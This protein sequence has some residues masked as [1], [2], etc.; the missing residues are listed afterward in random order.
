MWDIQGW[1]QLAATSNN[2]GDRSTS[3]SARAPCAALHCGPRLDRVRSHPSCAY[4][5]RTDSKANWIAWT[6]R[7]S[8]LPESTRTLLWTLL[9]TGLCALALFHLA[10]RENKQPVRYKV[11]SPKR[12]ETVEILDEPA[13]KVRIFAS[14]LLASL[15]STPALLTRFVTRPQ[16]RPQSSAMPLPRDSFSASSTPRLP[17]PLTGPSSRRRPRRPNGRPRLSANAEPSSVPCSN[18]S[19]TTRKRSAAWHASTAA[20]PWWMRSWVKSS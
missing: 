7:Y 15:D 6:N 10:F 2:G 11:P 16:A 3:G 13:I 4:I 1:R 12:P 14:R 5:V 20:R 17:T 8:D 18:M 19:W 9:W